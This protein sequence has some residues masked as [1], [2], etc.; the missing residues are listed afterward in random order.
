MPDMKLF[1]VTLYKET[2]N[3][4]KE[5]IYNNY[6]SAYVVAT[7]LESAS[8]VAKKNAPKGKQIVGVSER[9]GAFWHE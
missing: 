3:T 9:I 1:E 5:E 6:S 7:S 2:D 8:A 4:K